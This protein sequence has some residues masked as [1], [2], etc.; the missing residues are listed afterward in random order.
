MKRLMISSVLVLTAVLASCAST[1]RDVPRVGK[2]L[3]EAT[4]QNG[5]ACVRVN[6]IQG[7]GVLEGNVLSIDGRTGYYLATVLPGCTDLQTSARAL[8]SGGFGEFC[9]RTGNKVVTGGDQCTIGQM[10]EFENREEAFATYD[11]VL[12]RRKA[13]Q[14]PAPD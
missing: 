1:G 3:S 5:R 6:D 12:E 13:L 14:H 10:F 8:F 2:M 11:A 9:G 7:Y 4:G